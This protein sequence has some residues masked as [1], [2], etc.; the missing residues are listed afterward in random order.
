MMRLKITTH[1]IQLT[2]CQDIKEIKNSPSFCSQCMWAVNCHHCSP[3][4]D[5]IGLVFLY[6]H[7][8]DHIGC[9]GWVQWFNGLSDSIRVTQITRL[10]FSPARV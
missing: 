8:A 9:T 2:Q 10:H 5:S 6:I 7:D 3:N 4:N 1:N